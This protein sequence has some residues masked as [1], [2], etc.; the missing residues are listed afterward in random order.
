M[1]SGTYQWKSSIVTNLD[2]MHTGRLCLREP[3]LD[4]L[5]AVHRIHADPATNVY[6][7]AGPVRDVAQTR[8]M[9]EIWRRA[10]GETGHGYW[11]VR[12]SCGGPV[13]GVG[14]IQSKD[15]EGIPVFNLYYRFAPG[16]WGRGYAAETALAAMD[17]AAALPARPV[18]AVVHEDNGPSRRVAERTGMILTGTVLH[19]GSSRLIYESSRHPSFGALRRAAAEPGQGTSP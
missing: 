9:M 5:E 1:S 10:R 17:L 16:V 19:N 2:H 14:G 8:N 6:N 11:A 7:P 12:V 4:D 15:V 18:V 3:E 13:V